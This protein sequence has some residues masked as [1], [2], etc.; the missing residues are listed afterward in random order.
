MDTLGLGQGLGQCLNA[1]LDLPNLLKQ[2]HVGQVQDGL[3]R[4]QL[5][6]EGQSGL[7]CLQRLTLGLDSAPELLDVLLLVPDLLQRLVEVRLELPLGLLR[8]LDPLMEGLGLNTVECL[9]V[10]KIEL[11]RA[12]VNSNDRWQYFSDSHCPAF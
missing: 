6:S 1:L 11:I 8:L 3:L 5:G 7:R 9:I 4:G 10:F 12:H 2:Q